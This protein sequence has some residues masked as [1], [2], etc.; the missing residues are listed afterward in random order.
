MKLLIATGNPHK[1]QEIA[2][3]LAELGVPAGKLELLTLGDLGKTI[4]EA[5]EDA[6][7]FEGNAVKKARHYAA[8]SGLPCLADDS[9]LEV[10]ALGGQ[11]GVLSARYAGV[12]GPRAEVDLANNRKLLA[13]MRD[14]PLAQRTARFVCA[15]ALCDATAT[16]ATA[17][18]TVEGRI[19]TEQEA[20]DPSKPERG[21]GSNGF[22]YDPLFFMPDLGQTTAELAAEHKNRIS[23]RGAAT[24]LMWQRMRG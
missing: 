17:R 1:V 18:G 11:P 8:A 9:G 20:A 4:P 16:L 5:V 19:L 10:D 22:G 7:D 14:V 3:V 2:A 12:T 24:R 13:A 21:R 23:H 15:M 6:P